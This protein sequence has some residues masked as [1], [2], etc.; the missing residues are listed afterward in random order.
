LLLKRR[1]V[2]SH[3]SIGHIWLLA[4]DYAYSRTIGLFT[5]T[6][7]RCVEVARASTIANFGRRVDAHVVDPSRSEQQS[8]ADV[9]WIAASLS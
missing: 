5:Q 8:S 2:V 6:L 7:D 3:I 9:G 4:M 1:Q